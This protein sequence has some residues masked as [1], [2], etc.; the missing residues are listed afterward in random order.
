M[1]IQVHDTDKADEKAGEIASL[2][3]VKRVWPI[4]VV[5]VP[6][7]NVRVVGNAS[8]SVLGP[9]ADKSNDTFAPHV[10]TQVDKLR[11]KGITG[12]GVK[13]AVVDTGVSCPWCQRRD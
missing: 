3:S 12:K 9:R 5:R 11:A 1:S 7:E 13:I 6:D 4:Q 10:M 8:F 2:P